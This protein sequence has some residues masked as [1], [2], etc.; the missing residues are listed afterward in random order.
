MPRSRNIVEHTADALGARR[1]GSPIGCLGFV[2]GQTGPLKASHYKRAALQ[3][4][5]TRSIKI[6]ACFVPEADLTSEA[7]SP[8]LPLRGLGV[9]T[10]I[11]DLNLIVC[12]CKRW[13]VVIG[14]SLPPSHCSPPPRLGGVF[15]MASGISV[16][17]TLARQR[18]R[19]M[20]VGGNGRGH[21]SAYSKASSLSSELV[22]VEL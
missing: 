1:S 15:V 7:R 18:E 21:P 17:R 8:G 14:R 12:Q 3:P 10:E 20:K 9:E 6:D 19:R 2:A 13:P 16:T 4:I 5:E 22:R 11:R